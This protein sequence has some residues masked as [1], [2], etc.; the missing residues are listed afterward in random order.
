VFKTLSCLT[1]LMMIPALGVFGAPVYGTDAS[2]YLNGSRQAMVDLQGNNNYSQIKLD[3]D[4]DSLGG[5][6]WR[7]AYT[8]SNYSGQASGVS[9]FIIEIT[10][11]CLTG[12]LCIE[13]SSGN[14][15]L[16]TYSNANGNPGLPDGYSFVGVKFNYGGNS[17]VTYWLTSTRAPVWGNAYIKGGGGTGNG[18]GNGN[19]PGVNYALTYGVWNPSSSN[20]MDFVV[21]PDGD[22][23]QPPQELPE[24]ATYAAMGAGLVVLA[25]L[26]GKRVLQK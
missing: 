22:G 1:L 26:R 4:V 3:W 7:Y 6:L 25:L 9:H 10:P 17:P 2:G 20:L 15:S 18:N 8:L 12:E 5:G 11:T 13:E 23:G 24:P 16:E 19:S 14:H 21:R